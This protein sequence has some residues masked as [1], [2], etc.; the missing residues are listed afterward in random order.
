ME[1]GWTEADWAVPT[2]VVVSKELKWRQRTAGRAVR[3]QPRRR[4]PYFWLI[5][6]EWLP[7]ND[8]SWVLLPRQGLFQVARVDCYWVGRDLFWG[9]VSACCDR[10]HCLVFARRSWYKSWLGCWYSFFLVAA[11]TVTGASRMQ[12]GE[13]VSVFVDRR[14]GSGWVVSWKIKTVLKLL[15]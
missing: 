2:L 3:S 13:Q 1:L 9:C 5:F 6:F 10:W 11:L 8:Y 12:E 14:G 15:S 4:Q 7:L